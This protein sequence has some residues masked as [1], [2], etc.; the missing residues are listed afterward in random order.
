MGKDNLVVLVGYGDCYHKPT[1]REVR[2]AELLHTACRIC[3]KREVHDHELAEDCQ[4][5]RPENL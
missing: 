4:P 3:Y 5:T 1:W 2:G